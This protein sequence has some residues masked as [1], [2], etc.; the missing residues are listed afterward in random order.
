MYDINVAK[1]K[2][3]A[4][5]RLLRVQKL[6]RDCDSR[7]FSFS[8]QESDCRQKFRAGCRRRAKMF[9]YAFHCVK[10]STDK[11]SGWGV[12]LRMTISV[13]YGVEKLFFIF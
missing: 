10:L 1:T 6:R 8:R 9:T 2:I 12:K 3:N 13:D 7:R 4:S 5:N 11:K